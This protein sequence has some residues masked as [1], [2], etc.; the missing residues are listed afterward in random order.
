MGNLYSDAGGIGVVLLTTAHAPEFT[1]L[2]C[3]LLID[4][5]KSRFSAARG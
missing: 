1:L 3:P 4:R 5:G 2:C